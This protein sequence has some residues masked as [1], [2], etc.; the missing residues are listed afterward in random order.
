[1]QPTRYN[2]ARGSKIY[3][4]NGMVNPLR[5]MAVNPDNV[6]FVRYWQSTHTFGLLGLADST[7]T[8]NEVPFFNDEHFH[9][10]TDPDITDETE[11][12][13]M[14]GYVGVTALY[15]PKE[16]HALASARRWMYVLGEA[17][18]EEKWE[19]SNDVAFADFAAIESTAIYPFEGDAASLKAVLNYVTDGEG[20][21]LDFEWDGDELVFH[22]IFPDAIYLRDSDGIILGAYA[23]VDGQYTLTQADYD[24]YRTETPCTSVRIGFSYE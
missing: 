21:R 6:S 1:M 12:M 7:S 23:L 2:E 20:N 16:L 11:L 24:H 22:D 18:S 13:L 15:R 19:L 9:N 3:E 17:D 14:N 5:I 10:V 4:F 8:V